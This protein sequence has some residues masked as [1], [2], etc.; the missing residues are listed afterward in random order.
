MIRHRSYLVLLFYYSQIPYFYSNHTSLIVIIRRKFIWI[1]LY[2]ILWFIIWYYCIQWFL[3][4]HKFK[5]YLVCILINMYWITNY[6][7]IYFYNTN[8][9][10]LINSPY[11]MLFLYWNNFNIYSYFFN[12][13]F[14][15]NI[16]YN[17]LIDILVT[18]AILNNFI[19]L[20][21]LRSNYF[22]LV[23]NQ[24]FYYLFNI[25]LN[26]FLIFINIRNVVKYNYY[27]LL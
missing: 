26:N 7:Y 22:Q 20:K 25:N 24:L 1:R 17:C 13:F 19:L 21:Y 14:Y 27:C 12:S 4:I 6:N 18:D 23:L 16:L 2:K 10:L 15:L 3:L 8:Q 11:F 9:F 5:R